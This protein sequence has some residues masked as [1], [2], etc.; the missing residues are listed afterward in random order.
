MHITVLR[1]IPWEL[2][3]FKLLFTELSFY[4]KEKHYV[5]TEMYSAEYVCFKYVIPYKYLLWELYSKAFWL[6]LHDYLFVCFLAVIAPFKITL[7][8][9]FLDTENWWLIILSLL[10]SIGHSLSWP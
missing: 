10:F 2:W 8:R 4:I 7:Q 5:E 9:S 3:L 6:L 1:L